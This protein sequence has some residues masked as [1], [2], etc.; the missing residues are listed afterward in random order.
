MVAQKIRANTQRCEVL[1]GAGDWLR[2]ETF[3]DFRG[4]GLADLAELLLKQTAY[5]DRCSVFR[6]TYRQKKFIKAPCRS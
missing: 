4:T 3:L 1:L 5:R 2:L 6:R